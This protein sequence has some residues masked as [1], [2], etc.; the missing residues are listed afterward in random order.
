MAPTEYSGIRGYD[1]RTLAILLIMLVTTPTSATE[2]YCT[3]D[4]LKGTAMIRIIIT[5]EGVRIVPQIA[6]RSDGISRPKADT[7]STPAQRYW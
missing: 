6:Q 7:E 3:T 2:L 1:M 4:A 5:P